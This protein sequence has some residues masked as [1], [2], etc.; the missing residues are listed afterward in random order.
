MD[1]MW[2][3]LER[4]IREL[5]AAGQFGPS[6]KEESILAAEAVLGVELPTDLRESLGIHNGDALR[7]LEGGGWQSDGPFAHIEFLS[8]GAILSEWQQ[9]VDEI[10][11]AGLE[12]VAEGP[13][14]C[15]W[16]NPKWI[17]FTVIGG[18]TWH[19]CVDL[20][21]PPEGRMGQI[22]EI[23]D[24]DSVRRVAAPSYRAF[25]KEI[26]GDLDAGRYGLGE[27]DRLVHETWR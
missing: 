15:L 16:W 8:L 22:I 17:P 9:W 19:H 24:D 12:P 25:L 23:V 4:K 5:G 1:A 13:V 27:D 11:A 21:P 18:S 7:K 20:D 3:R 2:A 14:K 6:A 10:G 26:L